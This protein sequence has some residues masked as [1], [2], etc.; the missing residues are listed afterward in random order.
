VQAAMTAGSVEPDAMIEG[1]KALK[2]FPALTGNMTMNPDTR[3][4]AKEV[5]LVKMAG[6]T[7]E[8][9]GRRTPAFIPEP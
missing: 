1:I 4:P 9:V 8:L 3:I 6:A 2:D 5:T 7:P